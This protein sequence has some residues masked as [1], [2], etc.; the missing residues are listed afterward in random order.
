VHY[1]H[2]LPRPPPAASS[3]NPSTGLHLEP[4]L[5]IPTPDED[6]LPVESTFTDNETSGAEVD[7][8]EGPCNP[9]SVED[10]EPHTGN[11]PP[12]SRQVIEEQT[13]HFSLGSQ[14]FPHS[15]EPFDL[16]LV[17]DAYQE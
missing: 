12:Q 8:A 17:R 16:T 1:H 2:A 6:P 7:S 3:A 15:G 11:T 5:H 14:L 10:D 4:Q 9:P 13:T